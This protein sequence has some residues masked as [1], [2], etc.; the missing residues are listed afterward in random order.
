MLLEPTS[1]ILHKDPAVTSMAIECIVP[2]DGIVAGKSLVEHVKSS[3]CFDIK[4]TD[5]TNTKSEEAQYIAEAFQA[6]A[7]LLGDLHHESDIHVQALRLKKQP[8]DAPHLALLPPAK[9]R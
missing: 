7:D 2:E 4:I 8:L 6:F 3:F 1:R 5:E 9:I